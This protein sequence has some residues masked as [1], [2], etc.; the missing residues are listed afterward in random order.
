MLMVV[1]GGGSDADGGGVGVGVGIGVGVDVEAPW[2]HK[3]LLI[4][5]ISIMLT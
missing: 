4:S 3:P 1:H 5:P 2:H